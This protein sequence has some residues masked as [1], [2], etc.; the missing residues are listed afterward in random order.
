[1]IDEGVDKLGGEVVES[2]PASADMC[3]PAPESAYHSAW[4]GGL[5]AI[6]LKFCTKDSWFQ[7]PPCVGFQGTEWY[8]VPWNADVE[9]MLPP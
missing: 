5:S 3:D 4:A 9:G 6:M 2:I 7:A 8:G 1:M